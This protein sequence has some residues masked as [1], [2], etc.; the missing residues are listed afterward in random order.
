MQSLTYEER[1][2]MRNENYGS[3][4][5]SQRLR[6]GSGAGGMYKGSRGNG[7]GHR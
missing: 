3:N 1:S 2:A 6:D 7:G 4:G 5:T